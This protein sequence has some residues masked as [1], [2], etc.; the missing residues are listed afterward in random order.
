MYRIRYTYEG[1]RSEITGPQ[2]PE[3]AR[4]LARALRA[5]KEFNDVV[6]VAEMSIEVEF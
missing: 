4:S 2:H 6:L 1:E 5:S 3:M